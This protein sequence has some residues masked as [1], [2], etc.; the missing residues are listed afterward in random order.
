MEVEGVSEIQTAAR[1]PKAASGY[2]GPQ[3]LQT[4]QEPKGTASPTVRERKTI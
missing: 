3:P 4:E 2:T 1:S